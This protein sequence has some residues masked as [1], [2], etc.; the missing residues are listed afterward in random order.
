V[1]LA[2]RD[3]VVAGSLLLWS[4]ATLANGMA[5]SVTTF[6]VWRGVLGITEAFYVPAAVSVIGALHPGATRSRALAIHATAQM[7]GIVVGGWYGGWMADSWGW[8]PAFVVL[9]IVGIL[10]APLV[11]AR[12]GH[13]PRVEG[14]RL[15]PSS[16]SRVF[17]ARCYLAL[18]FSFFI[19]CIMLWMLYAWLPNY[20]YERYGLSMTDS[21]LL[22][23]L[24]LQASCAAGI[25][26]GGLLADHLVRRV[27][28]SRYYIASVG[29]LL[30][31]PFAYLTL[32]VNSLPLLKLT[33]AAFGFFAGL[34]I[35]NLFA[36]AYDVISQRN[37]GLA[38][39]T[40]NMLGG[41]A[42]GTAIFLAGKWKESI[43]IQTMMGWS[44][45]AAALSAILMAFVVATAFERDRERS[46]I[47]ET[48]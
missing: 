7:A 8:R 14:S 35:A 43:G 13:V 23:T 45:V 10:Y 18:S 28:A 2:R 33:S 27:R 11:W 4:L 44:A 38:A 19:F 5:G 17:T 47:G 41:L 37:Y 22:A 3:L 30:C 20:I 29:L 36:S 25:L 42:G 48:L 16:P 31:S 1:D 26:T 46:G 12:V 15:P 39:G 32:A 34:M 6:L 40:L 21:G 24:Y 9:A